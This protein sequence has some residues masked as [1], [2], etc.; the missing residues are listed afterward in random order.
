MLNQYRSRLLTSTLLVGAVLAAQ[1]VFAQAATPAATDEPAG[2]IVVTGSLIRNPSLISSA[3]VSVIGRQEVQ[4]RGSNT[5]EEVLR[6]LP[7]AVPSIGSAVNNG[8]GGASFVDLRGLGTNRNLVLLDGNR[9][10]PASLLGSTDLNDIPLALIERT[11]TLTGGAATTYG[12]DAVSG[13]VNFITR[14]DFSGAEVSLGSRITGAGD[15]P[16]Y[17]ADITVGA[18]FDDGRGNAV[19]SVGY[20]HADPVYQGDRNQS[21]F[22]VDSFSGATGAGAGSGTTVPARFTLR[23]G[24]RLQIN[25]TTGALVNSFQLYNFNPFNIFQTPFKRYNIYGA[26]HYDVADNITVYTRGLFSKNQVNTIVAPSGIFGVDLVIPYSNPYLP[27]AARNQFC[28]SNGLTAGQCTAAAAA[29]SPS[30]PNFRTFTTN[31]QRRTPDIGPRVSQYTT[32]YF[33]YRAGVKFDITKSINLD[34]SGGYGESTN[35]QQQLGYLLTSR[36]RAAVFATNTTSCLTSGLP[37]GASSDPG[38]V[39]LNLFGDNGSITPQQAAY[40]QVNAFNTVTTSLGQVRALLSGDFGYTAPWAS[41]PVSFAV[42]TEYRKYT[43]SQVADQVSAAAGQLGGAGGAVVPFHGAY[44]VVEG[45]G[46]VIVPLVENKPFFNSLQVEGGYRYSKYKISAAGNPSFNAS[47]YKAAGTWS[48]VEGIKFRGDYQHA[49]RAPSINELFNP[50]ST[51]L[52]SIT[53]DPCASFN[54]SNTRIQTLVPGTNLYNICLAQGATASTINSIRAPSAN[55]GNITSGG[56]INLRPEKANSYTLG[57]VINPRRFIPGLSLTVDYYHIKITNA[58]TTPTVADLLQSCF[59][60]S[61]YTSPPANAALPACT[62]IRRSASTGGLD[63]D[64]ATTPG[65]FAITSNQGTLATSGIDVGAN[66][67]RDLGFARLNMSF[68]GNWTRHAK[69]L[70]V[71]GGVNRECVGYYSANCGGA[72]APTTGQIGSLQPEFTWNQRTTLSFGA[73]DVSA[74]WRHI[75]RMTQEPL[76]RASTPGFI[77]TIS[78]GSLNGKKVNFQRIPAYN[79]VDL[80]A[81]LSVGDHLEFTATVQNMFDKDPPLVGTGIGAQSFNSGNTYPSTYDSLGRVFSAGIN[82]KF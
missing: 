6:V 28:A 59:G 78:G 18:N 39:P 8:N 81:R 48:P 13:V 41:A 24:S 58:I 33:D 4:L 72:G 14:R 32:Q 7:G 35:T 54:D 65:L 45:Y 26:A 36:A 44:D 56:N 21:L 53:V 71:P 46:E 2:E 15:G 19:L 68:Q 51:G 20:Q 50:V 22:N 79:Y 77:G 63:G 10:T 49:V 73:L 16:Y 25:P 43:A 27:V 74:L 34:V 66:Y 11:D 70:A 40:Q 12:A 75:D 42:G 1:P 61:P 82:M 30:D 3:P 5:A 57:V 67:R 31:V 64:P 55:Q 23:D 69:F 29:L 76:A 37:S 52:V 62:Q 17:R 38:C 9:L 60:P 47:T 80:S